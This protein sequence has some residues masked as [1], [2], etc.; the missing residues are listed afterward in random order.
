MV[1]LAMLAATSLLPAL[2]M[3]VGH[4]IRPAKNAEESGAIFGRV[5]SLVQRRAGL[6]AIVVAGGLLLL[7]GPFAGV[8][9]QIPGAES[10]PESLE[11][12]Q[13]LDVREERFAVGGEDPITIVASTA[14]DIAVYLN[15]V[16][17]VPDVAGAQVRFTTDAI[18]VIDVLPDGTAQSQVAE[19]VVMSE[20]EDDST[21]A[22]DRLLSDEAFMEGLF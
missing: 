2:L 14:G 18:T 5:A 12:R 21:P 20:T 16:E 10:L 11:T 3:L 19:D 15:A 9:L 4:R 8:R 17:E 6:V 7:A 13:L 22:V 1:I